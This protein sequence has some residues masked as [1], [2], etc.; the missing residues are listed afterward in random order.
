MGIGRVGVNQGAA[1]I[2]V[3]AG[4][5]VADKYMRREKPRRFDDLYWT[6]LSDPID[7]NDCTL[8]EVG[9]TKALR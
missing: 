3:A 1:A 2:Q 7:V 6:R 8:L 5:V 4:R 9:Q